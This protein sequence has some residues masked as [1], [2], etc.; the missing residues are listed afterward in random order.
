MVTR[1][2]VSAEYIRTCE[3][4]YLGLTG[5]RPILEHAE[6]PYEDLLVTQCGQ[7]MLVLAHLPCRH[8]DHALF[9]RRVD[10]LII[11]LIFSVHDDDVQRSTAKEDPVRPKPCNSGAEEDEEDGTRRLPKHLRTGIKVV[12]AICPIYVGSLGK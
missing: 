12:M 3:S 11:D 4:K 7:V 10:T 9:R 5:R 6:T 8:L 1:D 2:A